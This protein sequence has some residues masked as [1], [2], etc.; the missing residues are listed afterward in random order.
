M[1]AEQPLHSKQ[2]QHQC[3]DC[4]AAAH[5]IQRSWKLVQKR[6]NKKSTNYSNETVETSKILD[7]VKKPSKQKRINHTTIKQYETPKEIAFL[8]T[9][10]IWVQQVYL[11]IYLSIYI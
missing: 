4:S 7:K 2:V 1:K 9:L 8:H 6:Y 11:S 5:I 3:D 10:Q